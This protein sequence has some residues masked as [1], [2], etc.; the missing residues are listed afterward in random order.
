MVYAFDT[1][2]IIHI[3][4]SNIDHKTAYYFLRNNCITKEMT[5]S[6]WVRAAHIYADLKSK[7]FKVKGQDADILIAAFCIESG[8]TLV[9]NNT[10]DF[11]NID[12]L[13]MEDWVQ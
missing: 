5:E 13:Q 2:T 10:N 11:K 6:V 1:N 9:T 4:D 12:N 3:I 8:Y 7:G